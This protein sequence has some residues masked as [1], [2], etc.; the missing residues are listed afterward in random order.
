MRARRRAGRHGGVPRCRRASASGFAR[1]ARRGS[2]ER[3][4]REQADPVGDAVRRDAAQQVVVVPETQLD[5]NGVD[6]GDASGFLN[7]SDGDVAQ[8]DA[9]DETVALQR[10]ERAHT[11]RQRHARVRCVQLIEVDAIDAERPP[12]RL[13]GGDEMART[14]IGDPA[15]L[16]TSQAA[17]GG[18]D[19]A[20]A[21][22]VPA[23]ERARNQPLVV[24]GVVPSR[25][26]ASA[27]SRSVTPASNAACRTLTA[28]AS[29]RS[30]SVDSRIH[31]MP[32]TRPDV[33]GGHTTWIVAEECCAEL[34]SSQLSAVSASSRK[35][36]ADS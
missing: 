15:S 12:A 8:T 23:G 35:P 24:S 4:V 30:A 19:D 17:L 5:L 32:I 11:G 10:C 34:L 36:T 25:Q 29:S 16:R 9:G 22:A 21:V 27:V 7:L 33:S 28:R 26:Y 13:A 2:A 31:P 20:R 18:D 14:A 6:L 1:R 3:R